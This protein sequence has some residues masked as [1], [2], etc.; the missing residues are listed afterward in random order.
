MKLPNGDKALIDPH[1]IIDY[2]LSSLHEDG[3]HKA[4]LFSSILGLTIDQADQLVAALRR[5][6]AVG[7]ATVGKRDQY[8]QRYVIDF[9]F[10]GSGGA[11]TIRSAWIIKETETVPRLVTCYIL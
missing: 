4:H 11:G 9:E 7:D 8:G 1:K 6:A 5:A 10:A 3:Q 2:C